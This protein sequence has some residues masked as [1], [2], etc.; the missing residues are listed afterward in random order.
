MFVA[1]GP[2][3]HNLPLFWWDRNSPIAPHD[4][5]ADGIYTKTFTLPPACEDLSYPSDPTQVDTHPFPCNDLWLGPATAWNSYNQSYFA[6]NSGFVSNVSY[7]IQNHVS[8][9]AISYDLGNELGDIWLD[10]NPSAYVT[11]HAGNVFYHKQRGKLAEYVKKMW[12]IHHNLPGVVGFSIPA[13]GT[14]SQVDQKIRGTYQA[15]DATGKPRP[16][17]ISTHIYDDAT[18]DEAYA[19]FTQVHNSLNVLGMTGSHVVIGECY[20]NDWSN[21]ESLRNATIHTARPIKFLIQFPYV[22][23]VWGLGGQFYD[24]NAMGYPFNLYNFFGF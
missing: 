3:G 17:H 1:F 11:G 16:L 15:Y 8:G 4:W 20:H 23:P 10:P 19:I 18:G 7:H 2:L 9:I 6:E 14:V 21:A 12:N 22:R 24:A 13:G 5:D